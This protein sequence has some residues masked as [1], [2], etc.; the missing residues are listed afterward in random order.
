V[1]KRFVQSAKHNF[2]DFFL[3]LILGSLLSIV[4]TERLPFTLFD[5]VPYK[6]VEVTQFEQD[7]IFLYFSATFEKIECELQRFDV[8]AETFDRWERL[9]W[10]FQIC[11]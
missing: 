2:L 5:P 11:L 7:D 10:E 3:G 6:N 8:F 1:V 4:I 9:E